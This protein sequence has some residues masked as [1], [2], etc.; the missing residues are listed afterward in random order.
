ML[1]T[2]SPHDYRETVERLLAAIEQ[3]GITVFARIDHAAAAREVGLSLADEEVV[4][5]GNPKAGTGLMQE[6]P[7]VG[8]ELPLRIL[9]WGGKD[10]VHL[11][12]EDPRELAGSYALAGHTAVLDAMADLLESLV[13]EA[14]R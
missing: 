1:I 12:Y 13:G 2:R 5:F 10:G 6:D 7:T 3:R 14:S 4:V 8:I 11:G 9:I